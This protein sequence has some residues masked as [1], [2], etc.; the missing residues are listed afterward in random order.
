MNKYLAYILGAIVTFFTPL[1]DI[2]WVVGALSLADWVTGLIK[3]HKTEEGI[4][5][6]KIITKG[7]TTVGYFI[8]I[9]VAYSLELMLQNRYGSKVPFVDVVV[10]IIAAAEVQSLRENLKEI[11][12]IDIFK[13]VGQFFAKKK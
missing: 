5:S 10:F 13:Y 6:H 9:L 2:L 7:W 11:T 12:G 4:V 8:A 1:I 3:G